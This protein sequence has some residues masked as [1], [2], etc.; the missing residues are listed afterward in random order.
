[1]DPAGCVPVAG[2]RRCAQRHELARDL[3]AG[4]RHDAVATHGQDRQ[5]PRVVTGEHRDIGGSLAADRRDLFEVAAGLLD[6]DDPRMVSEPQER[7]GI[8][9]RAGP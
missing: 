4:D 8:D 1:V 5:C 2:S 6:G 7:G 3:V 9:V